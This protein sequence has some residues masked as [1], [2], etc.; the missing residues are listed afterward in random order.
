[1]D[2]QLRLV[3]RLLPAGLPAPGARDDRSTAC[4]AGLR[5][6]VSG[7][8]PD[9]PGGGSLRAY[10]PDTVQRTE[11][12]HRICRARS[13]SRTRGRGRVHPEPAR[14]RGR[15]AR[16]RGARRGL[17]RRLRR[18]AR[19]GQRR[20]R[21]RRRRPERRDALRLARAVLPP[22]QDAAL[23]RRDRRGRASRASWSP[24]TTPPRRPPAAAWAS[25]ATRASTSTSPAASSRAA[26]GWP[27]RRSASTRAPGGRGCSSSRR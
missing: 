15:R 1:M 16:R 25:C 10:P 24:P 9:R 21:P 4:G 20:S 17:A 18:P 14:R 2:V 27:T 23:H 6:V 3:V 19:R 5:G 12:D 7:A 8:D 22:G 11:I 13:S 26:P